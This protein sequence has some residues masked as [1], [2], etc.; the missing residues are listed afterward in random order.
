M[1]EGTLGTCVGGVRVSRQAVFVGEVCVGGRPH[2]SSGCV[3]VREAC[4]GGGHGA[5]GVSENWHLLR[6]PGIHA[7]TITQGM[8]EGDTRG[9]CIKV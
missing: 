6:P 3:C 8:E 2:L 4:V 5:K 9:C 7:Y 1:L